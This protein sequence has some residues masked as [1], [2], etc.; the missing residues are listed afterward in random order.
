MRQLLNKLRNNPSDEKPEPREEVRPCK[1]VKT[2]EKE[3]SF[4]TPDFSEDKKDEQE[5]KT[6][7][8]K[9]RLDRLEDKNTGAD[10]ELYIVN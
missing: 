7:E 6:G 3:V 5:E 8:L 10:E 2:E 9:K 4:D 1:V